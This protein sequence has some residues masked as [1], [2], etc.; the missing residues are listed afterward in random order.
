MEQIL[1][2]KEQE[3]LQKANNGVNLLNYNDDREKHYYITLRL[4]VDL[5]L[6]EQTEK[7]KIQSNLPFCDYSYMW[8]ENNLEKFFNDFNEW[9]S[10]PQFNEYKSYNRKRDNRFTNTNYEFPKFRTICIPF[11]SIKITLY[12]LAQA[13][14]TKSK[15]F[16]KGINFLDLVKHLCSQQRKATEQE[17]KDFNRFIE[18]KERLDDFKRQ[19]PKQNPYYSYRSDDEVKQPMKIT[20]T[21]AEYNKRLKAIEKEMT[22]IVGKYGFLEVPRIYYWEKDDEEDY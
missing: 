5:N 17:S 14:L 2:W 12:P 11:E 3:K 6:L 15:F 20:L 7:L 4:E 22:A 8:G 10:K 13:Y 21:R 19:I 16:K 9:V 18:L 1:D